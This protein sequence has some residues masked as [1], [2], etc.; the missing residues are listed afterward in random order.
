MVVRDFHENC[1]GETDALA[2]R[3]NETWFLDEFHVLPL[4]M[5]RNRLVEPLVRDRGAVRVSGRHKRELEKG[6]RPPIEHLN[7][8][9]VDLLALLDQCCMVI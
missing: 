7:I 8:L 2:G 5:A 6:R 3:D 9:R 4:R 1:C